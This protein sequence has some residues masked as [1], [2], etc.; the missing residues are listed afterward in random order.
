MISLRFS[1]FAHGCSIRTR[2]GGKWRLRE[3]LLYTQ[4]LLQKTHSRILNGSL[5]TLDTAPNLGATIVQIRVQ[6]APVAVVLVLDHVMVLVQ[7][8]LAGN[9][10]K[11]GSGFLLLFFRRLVII[12]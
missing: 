12:G 9:L 5:E 4:A 2:E 1:R 3:K 10:V 11:K 7:A 8:I 6:V